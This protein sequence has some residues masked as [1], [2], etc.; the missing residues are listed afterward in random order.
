M[1]CA[2]R[3]LTT[4][5][6][7][8]SSARKKALRR[9]HGNCATARDARAGDLKPADFGSNERAVPTYEDIQEYA[10]LEIDPAGITGR[11]KSDNVAEYS[12]PLQRIIEQELIQPKYLK[13]VSRRQLGFPGRRI[14]DIQQSVADRKWSAEEWQIARKWF[15]GAILHIQQQYENGKLK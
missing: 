12:A 14:L 1:S 15:D 2:A 8:C 4:I 3:R 6:S 10:V 9:A 5:Q 11:V 13:L 7:D